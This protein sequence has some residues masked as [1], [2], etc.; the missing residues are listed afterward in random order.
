MKLAPSMV[1]RLGKWAGDVLWWK[2]AREA[3]ADPLDLVARVMARG[4]WE[5]VQELQGLVGPQILKGALKNAAP[6]VFEPDAWN[7]WHRRLGLRLT[8]VPKRNL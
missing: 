1:R 3:L 4:T 7:Y 6:G 2:T 5:D 8:H